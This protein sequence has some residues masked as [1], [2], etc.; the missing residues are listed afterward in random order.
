MLARSGR[1][2]ATSGNRGQSRTWLRLVAALTTG[3]PDG[4][5]FVGT[6]SAA[7]GNKLFHHWAREIAQGATRPT[8]YAQNSGSP[9]STQY[10]AVSAVT[11]AGF[12]LVNGGCASVAHGST[13][14][15]NPVTITTGTTVTTGTHTVQV[16]ITEYSDSTC[17]TTD[18]RRRHAQRDDWQHDRRRGRAG[19][20]LP[21]ASCAS[22]TKCRRTSITP[23]TT[24]AG[25]VATT[26]AATTASS[27]PRTRTPA[28]TQLARPTPRTRASG[29]PYA[30]TWNF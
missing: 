8:R 15:L 26:P 22:Y 17:T 20:V 2:R 30:G 1:G 14:A 11:T 13:T 27:T 7:V 21:S 23:S 9:N 4:L 6:A 10:F 28:P 16:T 25:G 19:H 12:T 24:V 3:L 18:L 5:D 29:Q